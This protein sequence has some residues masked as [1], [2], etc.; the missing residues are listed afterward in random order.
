MQQISSRGVA[1]VITASVVA[2][3]ISGVGWAAESTGTTVQQ[4]A[5]QDT[6]AHQSKTSR[7]AHQTTH[8][9]PH[10]PSRHHREA[11]KTP[12]SHHTKPASKTTH[13]SHSSTGSESTT[14]TSTSVTH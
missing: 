7:H 8:K 13:P 11:K 1:Q 12:P 2:L 6:S 14:T 9:E 5:A 4:A 3:G 10:K